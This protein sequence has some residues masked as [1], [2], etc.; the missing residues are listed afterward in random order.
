MIRPV[1]VL[2]LAEQDLHQAR[3]WYEQ[4]Q[5]GLGAE[6]LKATNQDLQQIGEQP[7]QYPQIHGQ[8]RRAVMRRFP[9]L[10]YF[11]AETDRI[12]VLACLHSR[13]NPHIA[14]SRAP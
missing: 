5:R 4:R 14:R 7:L 9:Y 2:P 8:I 12:V 13:R 1:I 11:I 6:F 3:D 10:I